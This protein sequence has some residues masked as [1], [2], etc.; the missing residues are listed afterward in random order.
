MCQVSPH[1]RD[2]MRKRL[3]PFLVEERPGL[4]LEDVL[5]AMYNDFNEKNPEL[6]KISKWKEVLAE[7]VCLEHQKGVS[8]YLLG[9]RRHEL[10][11]DAGGVGG[12]R[13]AAEGAAAAD[14]PLLGRERR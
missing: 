11:V 1:Q 14:A 4:I 7:E 2:V 5:E 3:A 10:Q 13:C 6:L 8:L 9:S 12:G